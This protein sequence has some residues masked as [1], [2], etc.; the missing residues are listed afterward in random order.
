MFYFYWGTGQ[1]P[2]YMIEE[3]GSEDADEPKVSKALKGLSLMIYF[4]S[5]V[6][7]FQF[8]K[9]LNISHKLWTRKIELKQEHVLWQTTNITSL[10]ITSWSCVGVHSCHWNSSNSFILQYLLQIEYLFWTA[11]PPHIK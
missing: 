7:T 11:S 8:S 4:H 9:A 2:A 1:S 10:N 6:Q 3:E 5:T